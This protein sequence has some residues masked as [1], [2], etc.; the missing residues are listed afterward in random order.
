[1][2]K[3]TSASLS[4][5]STVLESCPAG[6]V[7]DRHQIQEAAAERNVGDMRAP[8]LVRSLDG[9]AAQKIREYLISWRRLCGPRLRPQG[10]YAHLARQLLHP[11]AT[12]AMALVRNR[13]VN[14]RKPRNGTA[15]NAFARKTA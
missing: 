4:D 2:T 14:R 10:R 5:T 6:P 7:H 1:M 9:N 11:L 3:R 8:H 13:A 15:E 12:D